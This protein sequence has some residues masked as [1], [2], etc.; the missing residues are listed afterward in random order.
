M[1]EHQ[2][3][4]SVLL[5]TQANQAKVILHLAKCA[6]YGSVCIGRSCVFASSTTY[7]LRAVLLTPS[8]VQLLL[9]PIVP[10]CVNQLAFSAARSMPFSSRNI[11]N[12]FDNQVLP[13]QEVGCITIWVFFEDYVAFQPDQKHQALSWSRIVIL[14]PVHYKGRVCAHCTITV[15]VS[16]ELTNLDN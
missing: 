2:R 9:V 7:Y 16:Y 12:R 3:E 13:I 14:V 4:G 8:L 10:R 11:L 15:M 1:A 5:E 6:A